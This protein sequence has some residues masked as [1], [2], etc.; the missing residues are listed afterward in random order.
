MN[1]TNFLK[2]IDVLT[3]QYSTD[4]LIAFVHDIGRV[5][6]EHCR[7]GFL[8][9]LKSAGGEAEKAANK[10]DI[11]FDEM[12]NH[13][14]GNLKSID[15]QE[16]TITGV[17]NEEYDDWYD[18]SD[19]EF[20]YEDN[21]GISDMLEEA[22]DFVHMCVDIERYREGFAVGKQMLEMEILCDRMTSRPS[23]A[24]WATMPPPL[25]WTCMGTSQKR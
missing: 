1:L 9:M 11:D 4:Q 18:G 20:Y 17:L 3:S 24:I 19:E 6:P 10:K 7:E 8:E 22:C 25:L 12:Y 21:S 23:R 5:C 2:Q 13:I 14:R 16:I 15:S